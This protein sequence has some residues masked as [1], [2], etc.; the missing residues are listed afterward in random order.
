MSRNNLPEDWDAQEHPSLEV[1]RQYQAGELSAAQS[2]H[3]ERHLVS[4]EMCSDL[5]E[6]MT[7]AQPARVK[8]AVRETRG[9]LKNLLAQ[10]KRKRKVFQWP[11]WQTAA[12]LLVLLFAIAE[13]VYHQYFAGANQGHFKPAPGATQASWQLRGVVLDDAGQAVNGASI[14]VQGTTTQSIT[15]HRGEFEVAFQ[16]EQAVILVSHPGYVPKEMPVR[17]SNHP[18][19]ITLAKA[20]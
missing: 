14:Q 20:D 10:K 1:L 17:S 6:G 13:V 9:R 3:L 11:V 2:H 16:T 18:I 15:N 8:L 5:L 7:M 19:E 4:C 12:V